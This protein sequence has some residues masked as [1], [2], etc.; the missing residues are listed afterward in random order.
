MLARVRAARVASRWALQR[1][2]VRNQWRDLLDFSDPARLATAAAEE[3]AVW[4]LEDLC[5]VRMLVGPERAWLCAAAQNGH[6]RATQWL[7]CRVPDPAGPI[8]VVDYAAESGNLDLVVWLYAACRERCTGRAMDMAAANGHIHVLRWLRIYDPRGAVCSDRAFLLAAGNGHLAVLD[9]LNRHFPRRL[10]PAVFDFAAADR[11]LHILLYLRKYGIAGDVAK[12]MAKFALV[13]NTAVVQWLHDAYRHPIGP[14]LVQIAVQ[15]GDIAAVRWILANQDGCVPQPEPVNKLPPGRVSPPASAIGRTNSV[16]SRSNSV[17]SRTNSVLSRT[18][19]IVFNTS[20]VGTSVVGASVVGSSVVGSTAV[21][22]AV[23]ST[24]AESVVSTS[25]RF[26]TR[27]ASRVKV[28]AS[29]VY[30]ATVL[31]RLDMVKLLYKHGAKITAQDAEA[32]AHGGTLQVVA[33]MASKAPEA[34][35]QQALE[36]AATAGNL[37]VVEFLV[38]NLR[39]VRWNLIHAARCAP[40]KMRARM[41]WVLTKSA[42]RR[43]SRTNMI[44]RVA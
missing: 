37:D 22:S 30:T 38:V 41:T 42:I 9:W 16:L 14:E 31:Q 25:S 7:Y 27:T 32:A 43:G 28:P 24:V 20:V 13:G 11:H 19:S 1:A 8:P 39:H 26:S 5:E 10:S 40:K 23:G 29:A 35:G 36:A 18:N 3:G 33:W 44:G 34:F 17:L 15:S 21:A 2:V 4:L 6:L 12:A